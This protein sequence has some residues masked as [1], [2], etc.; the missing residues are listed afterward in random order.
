MLYNFCLT[1]FMIKLTYNRKI[2]KTNFFYLWPWMTF[3][4]D[5]GSSGIFGILFI[6]VFPRSVQIYSSMRIIVNLLLF[7]DFF[8]R[9]I[10]WCALMHIRFQFLLL[11]LQL[12]SIW[13]KLM[14]SLTFTFSLV[15]FILFIKSEKEIKIVII[16]V[17][18]IILLPIIYL[19]LW[20][21]NFKRIICKIVL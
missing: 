3:L 11:S 10:N 18:V 15:T 21:V 9:S 17:I 1:Y 13:P 12:K 19:F 20:S 14:S 16:D 6:I 2:L 8:D 5:V 4:A 7:F